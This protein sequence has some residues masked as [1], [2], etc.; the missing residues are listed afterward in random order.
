MDLFVLG[1]RAQDLQIFIICLANIEAGV[2]MTPLSPFFCVFFGCVAV[3][4]CYCF[5]VWRCG[6][7]DVWRCGR[8]CCVGACL[9]VANINNLL[10][11]TYGGDFN[12]HPPPVYV[13]FVDVWLC[14]RLD[15]LRCSVLVWWLCCVLYLFVV[16][17][18]V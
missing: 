8:G 16:W 9:G 12:D 10:R 14:G 1:A 15:V 2:S 18:R 11:P 13:C 6:G 3:W 4:P 5:A 17:V 7:V